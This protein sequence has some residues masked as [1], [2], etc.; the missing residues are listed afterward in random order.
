MPVAGFA[1]FKKERLKAVPEGEIAPLPPAKP[2]PPATEFVPALRYVA[3]T[4]GTSTRPL[5][6]R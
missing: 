1:V 6:I 2:V 3:T 5:P 4:N